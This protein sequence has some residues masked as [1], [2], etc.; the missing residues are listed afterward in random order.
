MFFGRL[1]AF[2]PNDCARNVV[3]ERMGNIDTWA[4]V[5]GDA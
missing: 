1:T 2:E 5:S 4:I 3:P